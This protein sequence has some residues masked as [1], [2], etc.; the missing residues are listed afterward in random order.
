[1][2][3]AAASPSPGGGFLADLSRLEEARRQ[4]NALLAELEDLQSLRAAA[5]LSMA[6]DAM[7]AA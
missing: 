3:E 7:P 4:L 2:L 6:I 1:M 5:Y